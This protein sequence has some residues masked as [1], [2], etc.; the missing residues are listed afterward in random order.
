M[1]QAKN[2][3]GES[4]LF[5]ATLF[6]ILGRILSNIGVTATLIG[7]SPNIIIAGQTGLSYMTLLGII[8]VVV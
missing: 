6:F 5:K 7:D 8:E 3:L 2:F 4:S 1:L